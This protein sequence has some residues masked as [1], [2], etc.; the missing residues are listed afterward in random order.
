METFNQEKFRRMVQYIAYNSKGDEALG[1]T[2]LNKLL[3][4]ADFTAYRKLGRSISGIEYEHFPQGPV[5]KDMNF[6]RSYMVREMLI[7]VNEREYGGRR[8]QHVT[9]RYEPNMYIFSPEEIAILDDVIAWASEMNAAQ[10]TAL[11]HEEPGYKLTGMNEP[12][13]YRTAWLSSKP[14]T[15]EQIERGKEVAMRHGFMA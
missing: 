14:L 11:S 10:L 12:I 8:Q 2:K 4:Y 13:P 5:P 15:A 3:Y 1:V 7:Q 6:E 9:T